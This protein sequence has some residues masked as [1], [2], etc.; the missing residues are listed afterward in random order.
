M[1]QKQWQAVLL[2]VTALSFLTERITA[3]RCPMECAIP[4]PADDASL[5]P[6]PAYRVCTENL[7]A[8]EAQTASTVRALAGLPNGTSTPDILGA[9]RTNKCLAKLIAIH[10]ALVFEPCEIADE[11]KQLCRATCDAAAQS[12]PIYFNASEGADCASLRLSSEHPPR[13][14]ELSYGGPH[15]WLWVA[16]ISIAV[17]FSMLSTVGV[18]VQK[19]SMRRDEQ[20]PPELR[21][22]VLRQP[23]WMLGWCLLTSGSVV[24]FVAFGMAPQSLIAPI[25]ALSLVWNMLLS[26]VFQGEHITTRD[27]VATAIIFTGTTL[28][29]VFGARATPT[30]S[31][32]DLINLSLRCVCV[33][34]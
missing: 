22:S 27:L 17:L 3:P 10:C 13:C 31:L 11:T 4:A 2:A 16:G 14:F 28:T 5:C 6:R 8:Q 20:R 12:C 24:D 18:H 15:R 34:A 7:D 25:A 9:A 30:Y 21:R 23:L 29:V 19:Y 33:C 32:T 26:P 1:Q